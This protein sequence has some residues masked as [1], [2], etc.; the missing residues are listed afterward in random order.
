MIWLF[1]LQLAIGATQHY[2]KAKQDFAQRKFSEAVSEVDMALHESPDLVP[3]LVLKARLASF[4]HRPDVAK[5][6]LIT[7]ITVDPTS[8]EAQ[9]FL[10]LFYYNRNEFKLAISPLQAAQTLSPKGPLPVFYLA[11][12]QEA[13]GDKTQALDLYQQAEDLSLKKSPLSAS[14]LV[15]YGRLL[16]FLG[17]SQ[18]SLEKDRLAIE[19]D[20]ESREAQYE[21]AKNLDYEGDFKN[22]ALQ[23]E[24]ALTLPEIGATDAQIHFLLAKLY[25]KLKQ[26][27]LAK[28]HLGKFHA[29]SQTALLP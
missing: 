20:P 14:I 18:D 19:E 2:E 1:A 21:L 8:E 4:A 24:R 26:P 28:A 12:T 13:L 22:A 6:C 16:L 11:M 27:D 3:A 15:A 9:F 23:G 5:S 25:W 7:A 10:G 17:R 29:D